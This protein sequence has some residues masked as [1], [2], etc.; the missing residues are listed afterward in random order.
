VRRPR[1][2]TSATESARREARRG[3]VEETLL[4]GRRTFGV[5]VRLRKLEPEPDETFV[6]LHV[7]P[8]G[9]GERA[10]SPFTT[11]SLTRALARTS[12]EEP[13][14][15]GIDPGPQ[16]RTNRRGFSA[17]T[18]LH[19]NAFCLHARVRSSPHPSIPLAS[20]SCVP[21]RRGSRAPIS[22]RKSGPVVAFST[23]T[24]C[25]RYLRSQAATRAEWRT[26]GGRCVA[27][28]CH[29]PKTAA[30]P[31]TR[32]FSAS[33]DCTSRAR[34]SSELGFERLLARPEQD[35]ARGR[36]FVSRRSPS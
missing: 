36:R 31:R 16:A 4:V 29:P 19:R 2:L 24:L 1:G 20:Q 22:R 13:I 18:A 25:E 30:Y 33:P 27:G 7:G 17:A 11:T 14:L 23:D 34:R 5:A 35:R 8:S 3:E 26:V 6:T 9:G 10:S 28:I 15:V 12:R 32:R 21:R